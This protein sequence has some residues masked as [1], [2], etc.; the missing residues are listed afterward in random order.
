MDKYKKE[1]ADSLNRPLNKRERSRP[2]QDE[3]EQIVLALA[4]DQQRKS[5]HVPRWGPSVKPLTH[6]MWGP[7]GVWFHVQTC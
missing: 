2:K 7:Y 6:P 4:P 5:P 1:K 3:S